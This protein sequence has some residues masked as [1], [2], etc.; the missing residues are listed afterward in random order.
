MSSQS[1]GSA[2]T[3]SSSGVI[4]VHYHGS[5]MS[6]SG[7]IKQATSKTSSRPELRKLA[8]GYI[9]RHVAPHAALSSVFRSRSQIAIRRSNR[10]GSN[11]GYRI[12]REEVLQEGLSNFNI[13]TLFLIPGEIYLRIPPPGDNQ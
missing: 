5:A 4:P 1:A 11:H 6:G 3:F 13:G 8:Y 7:S 9:A 10:A 2:L 12:T